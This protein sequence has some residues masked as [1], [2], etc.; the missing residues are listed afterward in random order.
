MTHSLTVANPLPNALYH[1][2]KELRETLERIDVN[3]IVDTRIPTIEG[4]SILG[5]CRY[6]CDRLK[7]LPSVEP[8]LSLWPAFGLLEPWLFHR[9]SKTVGIVFHDPLPLRKQFGFG[10]ISRALARSFR[11]VDIKVVDHSPSAREALHTLF[12]RAIQVSLMHPIL[13]QQCFYNKPKST[14]LVAG[15]YK[16]VR[17]LDLL[18]ELGPLLRNLGL[19][20][21]IVGRGWPNNIKGWEVTSRFLAEDELSLELAQAAVVIIP[22]THFFQSGI[23]IRAL[24]QGTLSVSSDTSFTRQVFGNSP[25]NVLEPN[26]VS[27]WISA[28]QV[29]VDSP[30]TFATK[31]FQ[32]YRTNCDTSWKSGLSQIDGLNCLLVDKAKN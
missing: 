14:V 4:V 2:T 5:K 7:P 11:T 18:S 17:N 31:A 6:L 8:Y 12:P 19:E 27:A 3:M 30:Q 9:N 21:R 26:S 32:E 1:Y 24:E 25:I 28:I 29:A 13:S 10:H 23:M 16:P 20:T 15:Q 22:Y